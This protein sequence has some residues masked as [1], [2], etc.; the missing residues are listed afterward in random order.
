M[1][2]IRKAAALK[3]VLKRTLLKSVSV[4]EALSTPESSSKKKKYL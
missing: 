2:R 1:D 3:L 4:R